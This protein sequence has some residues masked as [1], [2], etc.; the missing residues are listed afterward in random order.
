MAEVEELC[1]L[2]DELKA[3][4]ILISPGY[5]Y[6]SV[7]RDIFLT[8]E[9]IHEKFRAIREFARKYKVC[10]TPTFLEFAAG[11]R[12][13]PCSPW[14]TVNLHA[15]GVEGPLLSDRGRGVPP[16]LGGILD[17]DGLGLLGEP[18]GPPLPELQ[19]AQR[20]RAQRRERRDD[21]PGRHSEA[22]CL[23]SGRLIRFERVACRYLTI[24]VGFRT[25]ASPVMFISDC[26]STM[27]MEPQVNIA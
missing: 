24:V 19:D 11:L 8:K 12:E 13:L 2:V 23:V 10:A 20:L 27:P 15:Q 9:Q 21:N 5:E 25:Q 7:D 17:E 14:S 16:G 6:E 1:Q 18:P 4:G 22:G 26:R 3:N